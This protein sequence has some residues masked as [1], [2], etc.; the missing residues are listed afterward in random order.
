MRHRIQLTLVH[1]FVVGRQKISAKH[2][3]KPTKL[4]VQIL[5]VIGWWLI[6]KPKSDWTREN[7]DNYQTL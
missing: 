3:Q 2:S 6:H 1:Q 4:S 7:G 5:S